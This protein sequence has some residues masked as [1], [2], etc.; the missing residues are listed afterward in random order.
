MAEVTNNSGAK[1][2]HEPLFHITRKSAVPFWKASLIRAIAIFAALVACGIVSLIL[3]GKNPFYIYKTMFDGAFSTKRKFWIFIRNAALLL[4]YSLAIVPAFKMKFWNL[5]ADGQVLMGGLATVACMLFLGGKMPDAAVIAIMLVAS[6][7]ASVI[8]AV[9]PAIF[10]A[11]FKTNESLFTLMMNY[12]AMGLVTY[13]INRV[14]KGGSGVLNP[15]GYANLPDIGG[16]QFAG[17]K[18]LLTIII[19]AVIT[20][21]MFI[22]LKYTKHGYEI[23]VVG[24]SENTARYIGIG[25]KKVIIR[26][27]ILSGVICGII[28]FVLVGGIDHTIRSDISAGRGFTAILIAWIAKFNPIFMVLMSLFVAFLEVGSGQVNT[29][30]QLDNSAF[31]SIIVGIIYLFIIGCDFFINY[32]ILLSAKARETLSKIGGIFKKKQTR[33]EPEETVGE[34]TVLEESDKTEDG[35]TE[36]EITENDFETADEK[37]DDRI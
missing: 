31:S 26:T 29:V 33:E 19:F 27:L 22:Y 1:K 8:W 5:G 32:R 17:R 25:V 14:V 36:S 2:L 21:F 9:L 4:G 30:F 24:E 16:A 12:I 18:F 13:F 35:K 23:S 15:I 10:K 20:A 6:I 7:A 28:G 3:I 11:F 34:E 37:E